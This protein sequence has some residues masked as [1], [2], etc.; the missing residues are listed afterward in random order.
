[1]LD[2][3]VGYQVVKGN[4]FK[5]ERSMYGGYYVTLILGDDEVIIGE[6]HLKLAQVLDIVR[7]LENV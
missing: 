3:K 5:V 2:K 7:R 1:M 4:G 6:G